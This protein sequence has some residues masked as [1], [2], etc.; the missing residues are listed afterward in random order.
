M[1]SGPY[2]AHA[3]M[4]RPWPINHRPTTM[5]RA[6]EALL[7][8]A[9]PTDVIVMYK[10][11]GHSAQTL[12]LVCRDSLA[13]LISLSVEVSI[14][15]EGH[16][17]HVTWCADPGFLHDCR[18]LT[19]WVVALRAGGRRSAYPRYILRCR[20][21]GAAVRGD[22]RLQRCCESMLR[23]ATQPVHI[24]CRVGHAASLY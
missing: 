6:G 15:V 23:A 5:G 24:R 14:A 18:R 8:L 7:A 4:P 11:Q 20:R 17:L 19:S 22:A 3:C 13:T 1:R 21:A 9:H 2:A 10:V 16:R 12:R